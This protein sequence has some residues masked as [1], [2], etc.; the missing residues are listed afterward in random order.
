MRIARWSNGTGMHTIDH[1]T[2][3][4]LYLAYATVPLDGLL[5]V[6]GQP[7]LAPAAGVALVVILLAQAAANVVLLH[8]G[9]A[10]YLGGA[11]PKKRL[12]LLAVAR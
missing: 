11:P 10:H 1:A 9:I 2:R 7:D 3:W 6:L 12:I 4:P 8:R 5:V